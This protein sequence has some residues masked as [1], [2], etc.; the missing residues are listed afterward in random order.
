MD[1]NSCEK[2]EKLETPFKKFIF[3]KYSSESGE[4]SMDGSYSMIV[5]S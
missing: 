3:L 2:S 5:A 4:M 1:L